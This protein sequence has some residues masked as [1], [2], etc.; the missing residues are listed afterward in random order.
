[1]PRAKTLPAWVVP[2]EESV[3][4]EAA[5]YVEMSPEERARVLASVCRSAARLL[6]SRPDRERVLQMQDALPV[7]AI[8]ALARLRAAARGAAGRNTRSD[9]AGDRGA[10][11][12]PPEH[13]RDRA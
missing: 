12:P 11:C 3:R 8:V 2:E 6:A 13:G 9:S 1:M 4:R 10:P 5:P 7:S